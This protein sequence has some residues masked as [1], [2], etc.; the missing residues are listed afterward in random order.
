MSN[1]EFSPLTRRDFLKFLPGV[2]AVTVGV[3][4]FLVSDGIVQDILS[5]S[6]VDFSSCKPPRL[7]RPEHN[8][9]PVFR[10]ATVSLQSN[11]G[12]GS[13][14]LLRHS[15]G[16]LSITTVLHV[17][18]LS[19]DECMFATVPGTGVTGALDWERSVKWGRNP[20]VPDDVVSFVMTPSHRRVVQEAIDRGAIT[21]LQMSEK[22]VKKGDRVGT[23]NPLNGKVGYLE[24]TNTSFDQIIMRV[25]TGE[26]CQGWSGNP[27]LRWSPSRQTLTNEVVGVHF[28]AFHTY[29]KEDGRECSN[30]VAYAINV[31]K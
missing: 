15:N 16:G 26:V 29:E 27:T 13:G 30:N 23:P 6:K 7:G 22:S 24:V 17:A 28:G 21:P 31:H 1:T 10:A 3:I 18:E 5:N 9:D 4:T 11:A 19:R 2:S 25:E 8:S 20:L 14:F 12:S